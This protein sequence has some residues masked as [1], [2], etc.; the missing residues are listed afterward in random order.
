MTVHN[1]AAI[2]GDE[3]CNCWG[4]FSGWKPYMPALVGQPSLHGDY[5]CMVYWNKGALWR[6]CRLKNVRPLFLLFVFF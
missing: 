5:A 4:H 1:T 3:L 6:N 2:F